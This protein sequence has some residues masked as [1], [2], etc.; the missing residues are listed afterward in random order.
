VSAVFSA[1]VAPLLRIAAYT[2]GRGMLRPAD[3]RELVREINFAVACHALT[4]EPPEPEFTD[5]TN[6]CLREVPR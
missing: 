6:G 5:D 1:S 3:A 2:A 4:P